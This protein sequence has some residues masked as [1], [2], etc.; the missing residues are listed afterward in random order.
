M[1]NQVLLSSLKNT[2]SQLVLDRHVKIRQMVF[3]KLLYFNFLTFTWLGCETRHLADVI[4]LIDWL[5]FSVNFST[6]SAISWLKQI[7]LI[8]F[9]NYK[10]LRDK[11][12]SVY[13]T[14][15]SDVIWD[16]KLIFTKR[17]YSIIC[18]KISQHHPLPVI[19]LDSR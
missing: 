4:W 2:V 18:Y 13:K 11:N 12:L 19:T 6:I 14:I 8:H 17:Y 1:L 10:T 7:L 3:R 15:G 9:L 5:V 16:Y